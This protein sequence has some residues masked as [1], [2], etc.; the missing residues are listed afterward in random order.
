MK[1]KQVIE[2]MLTSRIQN[3][4]IPGLASQLVTNGRVRVFTQT[5]EQ[6]SLVVPHSH[7]FDLACCV[8]EGSVENTFWQKSAPGNFRASEFAVTEAFYEG[9][10]GSYRV[11]ELPRAHFV[12]YSI[13][14]SQNEWYAMSS[15]EIH[16]V[17]FSKGAVV[18]LFEGPAKSEFS[19]ALEPIVNGVRI[20]LFKVEDWMF[21]LKED[22]S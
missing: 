4:I 10:P 16:S 11:D 6:M 14:Y 12:P 20:P 21:N 5:T 13:T 22:V 8:I 7:R 18:L 19:V 17:R 15:E 2:S 3:Y 1:Q 9:N